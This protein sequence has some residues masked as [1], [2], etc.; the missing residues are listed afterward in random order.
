MSAK[1][2]SGGGEQGH[3]WPAV[4]GTYFNSNKKKTRLKHA[5][6]KVNTLERSI[7]RTRR[8]DNLRRCIVLVLCR[9]SDAEDFLKHFIIIIISLFQEDNIFGTNASLTHGPRLQR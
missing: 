9:P 7:K 4:Y 5:A 8:K 6:G 1:F 3:F 2:P